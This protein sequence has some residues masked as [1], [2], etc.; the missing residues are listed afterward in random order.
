MAN[1]M[2]ARD[3]ANTVVANKLTNPASMHWMNADKKASKKASKKAKESKV[4]C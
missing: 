4:K 2:T 3:P 1:T